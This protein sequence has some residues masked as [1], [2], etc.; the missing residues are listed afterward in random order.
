MHLRKTR[1]YKIFYKKDF[2]GKHSLKIQTVVKIV[3]FH[4][5]IT[6][7]FRIMTDATKIFLKKTVLPGPPISQINPFK[8]RK[9]S[10]VV[11]FQLVLANNF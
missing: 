8:D 3:Y 11:Y 4:L 7:N 10:I 5:F 2:Y 9:S 1:A 6:I